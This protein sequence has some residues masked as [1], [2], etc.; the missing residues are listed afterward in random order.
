M[1]HHRK[2]QDGAFW[3]RLIDQSST[4]LGRVCLL[5]FVIFFLFPFSG[6]SGNHS[7]REFCK[8]QKDIEITGMETLLHFP[9]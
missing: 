7:R 8:V 6:E 4:R 5:F 2:G 1:Q 9:I 3:E